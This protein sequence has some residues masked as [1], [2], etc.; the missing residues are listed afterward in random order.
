M[1]ED[2]FAHWAKKDGAWLTVAEVYVA[3]YCNGP[4]CAP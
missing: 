1:S 3:L 4:I 2:Y